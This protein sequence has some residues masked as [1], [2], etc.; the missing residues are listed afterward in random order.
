M[1]NAPSTPGTLDT[2]LLDIERVLGDEYEALQT[3]DGSVI[4]DAASRKMALEERLRPF[5]GKSAATPE[6]CALI[7]R[8]RTAAQRNH[9]LLIHARACMRNAVDIAAGR[10]PT[11]T[12]YRHASAASFAPVRVN[13]KG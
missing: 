7:E 11:A 2:T 1:M 3:L 9:A 6:T 5:V 12:T 13:I 4:A 8:V 10:A